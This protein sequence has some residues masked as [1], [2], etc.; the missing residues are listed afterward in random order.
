MKYSWVPFDWDHETIWVRLPLKIWKYRTPQ[1]CASMTLH[2]RREP[3]TFGLS[4]KLLPSEPM[5]K[6]PTMSVSN[7]SQSTTLSDYR[8]LSSRDNC[9]TPDTNLDRLMILIQFNSLHNPILKIRFS[10]Q[11]LECEP[12]LKFLIDISNWFYH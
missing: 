5:S 3:G 11:Q 9:L 8:S 12:F 2:A 1:K 7:L 10:C 6:Y 4:R